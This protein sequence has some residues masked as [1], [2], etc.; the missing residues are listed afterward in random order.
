MKQGPVCPCYNLLIVC[1]YRPSHYPS[2]CLTRLSGWVT[3]YQSKVVWVEGEGH[4]ACFCHHCSVHAP[5]YNFIKRKDS[6]FN[7][8]LLILMI[9]ILPWTCVCTA[10]G[11]FQVTHFDF[12]YFFFISISTSFIIFINDK[13]YAHL[14]LIDSYAIF[15]ISMVFFLN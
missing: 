7:Y 4:V 12:S 5:L 13:R 6:I 8:L 15:Y 9:I 1:I 14:N 2:A 3:L 11:M 10:H